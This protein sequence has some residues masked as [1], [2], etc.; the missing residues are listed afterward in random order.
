MTLVAA[1]SW[2][3]IYSQTPTSSLYFDTRTVNKF[4]CLKGMGIMVCSFFSMRAGCVGGR[5][6][7]SILNPPVVPSSRRRGAAERAGGAF[8]IPW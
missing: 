6:T 1:S 4:V 2:T 3:F 8:L 5:D 7:V